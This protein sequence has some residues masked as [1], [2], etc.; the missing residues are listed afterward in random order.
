MATPGAPDRHAQDELRWSEW[1][2]SAQEGD[3]EAYRKL[4]GELGPVVQAFLRK[5]LGDTPLLDDCL[6]EAL[7][8]V[9]KVRHTYDPARPFRPW[10]FAI[11][12]H[13][14]IDALRRQGARREDPE[15]LDESRLDESQLGD[16]ASQ[17]AAETRDRILDA[18]RLLGR[19]QPEH[20]DAVLLTKLQGFSVEEA[21]AREG[22]TISAMKTRIHRGLRKLRRVL[23]TEGG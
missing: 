23:E 6:Q 18:A 20:R 2:A 14:A 16:A 10:L 22:V 19:L 7:L 1:M 11:V 3:R 15:G 21:A 5:A 8:A 4:L 12:R 17:N 13:K 9:H